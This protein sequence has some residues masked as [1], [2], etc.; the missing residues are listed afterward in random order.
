MFERKIDGIFRDLPNTFGI[1]IDNLIV[2]YFS[3]GVSHDK[4]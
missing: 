1:A 2:Y 4:A 3:D